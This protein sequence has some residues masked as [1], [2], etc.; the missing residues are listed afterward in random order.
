MSHIFND[1]NLQIT[2][3]ESED[4]CVIGIYR[5]HNDTN[6]TMQL[7][8]LI[9]DADSCS[10]LVIGDLNVCSRTASNHPV[11]LLLRQKGFHLLVTEA[12]HFGGNALDQ[13]W[14]RAPTIDTSHVYD[15]EIYSTYFNCKDHDA[16]LFTFHTQKE[17][18][19]H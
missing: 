3:F 6:V 15:T 11:L 10:C 5:S 12:T 2:V 18:R 19:M 14:L 7:A 13:V 1:E 9:P 16:I 8:H 4:L 17:K